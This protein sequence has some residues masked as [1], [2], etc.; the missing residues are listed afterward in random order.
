MAGTEICVGGGQHSASS[1]SASAQAY[2]TGFGF[3]WNSADPFAI[4]YPLILSQYRPVGQAAGGA[5]DALAT[6]CMMTRAMLFCNS[7]P[8]DCGVTP[9]FASGVA[10]LRSA[11]GLGLQG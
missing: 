9:N 11:S 3:S 4:V 2:V 7:T 1:L 10:S 8:D 5:W 6:A